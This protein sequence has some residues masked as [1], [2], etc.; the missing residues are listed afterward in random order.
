MNDFLDQIGFIEP[1]LGFKALTSQKLF[2]KFG[3]NGKNG[4]FS[5]YSIFAFWVSLMFFYV[6][7]RTK[8]LGNPFKPLSTIQDC[9]KY[10]ILP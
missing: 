10:H 6:Y 7:L 1:R 8:I 9:L 2:K 3:K 4:K 5:P